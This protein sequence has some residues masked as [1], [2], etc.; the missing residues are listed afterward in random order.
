MSISRLFH[1]SA[2]GLSAYQQAMTVSSNNISNA[3]NPNYVRQKVVFGTEAGDASN[4][5]V[6]GG[7]KIEDVVRVKNKILDNQH[8]TYSQ[9]NGLAA[10][11]SLYLG[12]IESM[13]SE[14]GENGLSALMN[15][16]FNSWN[17]LS[18]Q[19][20]SIALRQNVIRSAEEMSA[21][22]KSIYEGLNN[23]KP[24]LQAEA[25]STVEK[26]NLY[27]KEIT[28]LNKQIFESKLAGVSSN[29]L[30]DRRDQVIQELSKLANIQVTID[31]EEMASVSIGGVLAADKLTTNEFTVVTTS[32]S[33]KVVTKQGTSPLAITGGEMGALIN[34]Y[35]TTIQGYLSTLDTL[36]NSLTTKVNDIH[37]KGY[38]LLV[39]ATQG[40]EFFSSYT[41]GNIVINPQV[42]KD[43]RLLSISA[44]GTPGNNSLALELSGIKD[45]KL[46]DGKTIPG[47]YSEFVSSVAHAINSNEQAQESTSLV[48]QQLDNQREEFSGVS[49]DE[50]MVNILKYQRSYDAAAKLIKVA[51]E[52]FETL[53]NVV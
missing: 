31:N 34:T 43:P 30:L 24:D 36:A 6:G 23:L 39:P 16:F 9:Q 3:N 40:T 19:P 12:Q 42:V 11:Q 5:S 17:E 35:S 47:T 4:R 45:A 25:T 48:L 28:A 20:E 1:I 22:F 21:K 52:L 33:L 32:E 53:L 51:D 38:S 26:I 49:V 37:R 7:I 2:R 44:D 14:P 13:L 29:N 15:K 8:R 50:E 18:A 46:A 27:A 41:P 10:K